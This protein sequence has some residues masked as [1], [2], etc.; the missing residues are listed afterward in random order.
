MINKYTELGKSFFNDMF[1]YHQKT[2]RNIL[3]S[4]TLC[5]LNIHKVEQSYMKPRLIP[6]KGKNFEYTQRLRYCKWC[7]V[8]IENKHFKEEVKI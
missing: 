6:I 1:I 3:L 4:K 8:I 5:K 2:K 7:R